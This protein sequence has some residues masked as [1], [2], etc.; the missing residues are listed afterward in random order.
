DGADRRAGEAAAQVQLRALLAQALPRRHRPDVQRRRRA[1]GQCGAAVRDALY[2]RRHGQ[3]EQP[4]WRT[5]PAAL[6]KR[7]L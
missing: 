7:H 6:R 4:S 3:P 2:R 1:S 5:R